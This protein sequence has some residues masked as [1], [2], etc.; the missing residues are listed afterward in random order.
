MSSIFHERYNKGYEFQEYIKLLLGQSGYF[1][2]QIYSTGIPGSLDQFKRLK[3]AGMTS[4]TSPDILIANKWM[5]DSPTIEF[6]FGLSCSR[7]DTLFD[8]FGFKSVT[9][10]RYQR[11]ILESIRKTKKL[12]I[13][14]IFGKKIEKN[15]GIGVT[16]LREPDFIRHL[17]DGSTGNPRFTD[18]YY[19][20]KLMKWKDFIQERCGKEDKEPN[21]QYLNDVEIPWLSDI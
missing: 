6:R 5:E 14:M 11:M 17:T 19:V 21:L 8:N 4:Y 12:E 10:P 7:R 16:P 9:Y 20:E 13:Y 18:V 1:E 2:G 3:D 15:F